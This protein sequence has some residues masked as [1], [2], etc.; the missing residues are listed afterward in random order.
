VQTIKM[1]FLRPPRDIK[2]SNGI[3][4]TS[5]GVTL[6]RGWPGE[7][8]DLSETA[9]NVEK[10][11]RR[12]IWRRCDFSLSP[13]TKKTPNPLR[14]RGQLGITKNHLLSLSGPLPFGS[15]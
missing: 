2:V 9:E 12:K 7:A 15:L 14:A 13:F 6:V 11:A 4:N 5:R 8:A 10:D 1:K 3:G